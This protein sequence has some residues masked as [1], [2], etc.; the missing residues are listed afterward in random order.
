MSMIK[1]GSAIGRKPALPGRIGS[2]VGGALKRGAGTLL[3]GGLGQLGARG[4]RHRGKGI[5]ARELRGFRK[6][7]NLLHRVGM[8]PRHL[9]RIRS[10]R[11]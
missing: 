7:V 3:R 4:H 10:R 6:V 2:R 8:Q 9:G 5:T 11:T 1:G